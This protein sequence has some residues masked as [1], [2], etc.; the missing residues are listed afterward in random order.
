M[1][2]EEID[3]TFFSIHNYF[4]IEINSRRKYLL[5]AQFHNRQGKEEIDKNE[6]QIDAWFTIILSALVRLVQNPVVYTFVWCQPKYKY[7]V[8][9]LSFTNYTCHKIITNKTV[10]NCNREWQHYIQHCFVISKYNKFLWFYYCIVNC[11]LCTQKC[12]TCT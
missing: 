11:W 9:I 12:I 1:K 6:W 2:Y 8:S 10:Q 7:I 3:W 4:F 5:F